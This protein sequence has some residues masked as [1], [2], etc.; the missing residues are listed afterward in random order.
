MLNRQY[1][2]GSTIVSE[3]NS[4]DIVKTEYVPENKTLY[5]KFK[6][7]NVYKYYPVEDVLHQQFCLAESQ[8][9]FF[10]LEIKNNSKITA[11]LIH[12]ASRR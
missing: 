1:N 6:S 12:K 10:S 2:E 5:V 3:F 9:K 11:V 8:G 7:G 4:N